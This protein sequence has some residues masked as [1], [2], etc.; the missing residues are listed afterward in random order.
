[1]HKARSDQRKRVRDSRDEKFKAA[2][3]V[4]LAWMYKRDTGMD[5]E[6]EINTQGTLMR[7]TKNTCIKDYL[8]LLPRRATTAPKPG[9]LTTA[10]NKKNKILRPGASWILF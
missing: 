10:P 1:M 5:Y 2:K 4:K 3:K 9:I 6:S 8:T 7:P